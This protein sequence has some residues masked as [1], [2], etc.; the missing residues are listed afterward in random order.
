M[1]ITFVCSQGAQTSFDG[2]L[3]RF[4]NDLRNLKSLLPSP[5][6]ASPA[7]SIASK[8]MEELLSSLTEHSHA[9]AELLT[10]LTRH[11]DLCVTAVRTTE[12]GAAL[13]RRKAAEVTQSQLE[14]GESVSISGVIAEQ[15]SQVP[16]LEPITPEERAEMLH[17]VV[18]DASEVDGVVKDLE[19]RLA[20]MQLL[21][22]VVMEHVEQSKARQL[23]TA[24]AFRVLEEIGTRLQSYVAA[25]TEFTDRWEEEK[26]A[27]FAKM[28]EMDGLRVFYEGYA[29]AYDNLI[30]EVDRRRAAE[31]KIKAVW[32]RAKENVDK[33]VEVDAKERQLFRQEV[34]E[35]LPT[36][37]WTGMSGVIK[38]WNVVP[39]AENHASS[40]LTMAVSTPQLGKAAVD[41]ARERLEAARQSLQ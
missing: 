8:P 10:S 7:D 34:G 41:R 30:L 32:R 3:L 11:F 29:S 21:H 38:T 33:I 18:Q 15:E 1:L 20:V 19:D 14:V 39:I 16:D 27:I 23:S 26:S 37:L 17:V 4:D 24:Q 2:D 5:S 28:D 40:T 35:Y 36:D 22:A 25:E 31:D 13:A 9:M 12:G 6:P